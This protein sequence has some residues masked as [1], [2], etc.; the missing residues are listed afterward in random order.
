VKGKELSDVATAYVRAR[1]ADPMCSFGDFV[2]ISHEVDAATAQILKIEV[3]DGII[4]PG[5]QAEAL[6][7]LKAKKGG[8]FIVLQADATFVPPDMEYRMVGGMGFMQKRNDLLFDDTRLQKVVTKQKELPDS[9]KQDMILASIAIKYT[10]SNSVGYAKGGMMVGVGAGQQSRVDCVKLAARKASTW[11]LRF[12]PKVMGLAFKEGVKRQD[13]VNAR[14]RYIEGDMDA[15]ELAQWE[16]NFDAAP[17]PM[18]AEEKASFVQGLT[19][20]TISSDAFFPFRDS[21]DHASKIGVK[22]VAQPGGSV[23][24]EEVISACDAYGMTMAFTDL[25]LFHH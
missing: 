13:R 24:D 10:Q 1:N 11:R 21:I 6:E 12:H 23:A 19:D 8:K 7:I 15:A 3:S 20:V 25:R 18:T 16:K 5:F 4:A 14:V 17:E 9:I 2:A 22:Y